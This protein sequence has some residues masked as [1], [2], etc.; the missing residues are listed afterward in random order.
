[1]GPEY[2]ARFLE[3]F[4]RGELVMEALTSADVDRVVD[5]VR[6]YGDFPLGTVDA[7]VVAVAERLKVKDIATLDRTHFSVVRPRHVGT[8]DLQP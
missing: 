4:R 1:M 7:S 2:E 8:F 6:Q 5:L 3:A